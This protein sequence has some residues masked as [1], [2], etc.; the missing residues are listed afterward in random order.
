MDKLITI[1][2]VDD[3]AIVRYTLE[4]L[5]SAR[6]VKILFAENGEIGLQ[7]ALAFQP[8]AILLDVMMPGM[9]GYETCR[10][11]RATPAIAEIPVIM[12]SALDDRNSRLA[13]LVA[14][15][16]DFLTK[17]FDGF[18]IEVRIKNI[19]RINRYR[20]LLAERSRFYWVVDDN[21]KGYLMLD[22]G[23]RIQYA[24]QRAQIY[25]HLPEN[26]TNI[27]FDEQISRYYQSHSAQEGQDLPLDGSAFYLVQPESATARAFWLRVEILNLTSAISKQK[28]VRMSDVT[29]E[30]SAYQ[31]VRKIHM[32]VAHKL[33]TPVAL[34]YSTMNLL[35]TKMDLIP[36]DQ[37]KPMVKT[38]WQS[39]ERLVQEVREMLKYIDAPLALASGVPFRL[40]SLPALI[41][42]VQE[43]LEIEPATVSLPDSLTQLELG[44]SANALE[45]ICNEIL[46]NAQKFH[47][48]HTPQVQVRVESYPG[49][50]VQL[51]FL[52]DGQAM[53]AEQIARAKLPYSQSEKWF[54]G[55]VAGMGLGLP[56]VA[57]L[58]WQSGG[59][60]RIANREDQTGICVSVILPILDVTKG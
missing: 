47:P 19:T 10:Q 5:L 13:G 49:D 36:A 38:A 3:D 6:D 60:V 54:T 42:S 14:G 45:L 26:Y 22:D 1:L 34:I 37:V 7:K 8:D 58:V 12:I 48:N 51:Q 29:D 43:I 30:M 11:I 17:P 32:L 40:K 50:S 15:A 28:L 4:S 21:E 55:E 57:T 46:E 59:Q 53:T 41:V 52:D 18:E 39:A 9:D 44:I 31:D 35:D 16:D 24:N 56:L 2:I 27:Y 23:R 20:N 33:R 25:L